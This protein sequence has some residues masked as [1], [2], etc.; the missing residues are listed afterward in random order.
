MKENRPY[1]EVFIRTPLLPVTIVE[2]LFSNFSAEKL[3]QVYNDNQILQEALYVASPSLYY[4]LKEELRIKA[5]CQDKKLIQSL[6][7][8]LIRSSTRCTPFGLFASIHRSEISHESTRILLSEDIKYNLRLDMDCLCRIADEA[9][10]S[11]DVQ[12]SLLYKFNNSAYKVHDKIRY[13]EYFNKYNTRHHFL[14]DINFNKVLSKLMHYQRRQIEYNECIDKIKKMGYEESEAE[15]YM[16]SLIKSQVLISN[17][18]PNVSGQEY[19]FHLFEG[20]KNFKPYE[21]SIRKIINILSKEDIPISNKARE[22]KEEMSNCFSIPIN[23]N[24][25]IQVDSMRKVVSSK[26]NEKVF[27][28]INRAAK[29]LYLLSSERETLLSLEKFKSEFVKKYGLS[30]VPLLLALDKDIGIAYGL[31][32]APSKEGSLGR[33]KNDIEKYKFELYH[34]AVKSDTYQVEIT[35]EDLDKLGNE[36]N[37]ISLNTYS[38]LGRILNSSLKHNIVVHGFHSNIANLIGRFGHLDKEIENACKALAIREEANSPDKIFAEIVHIP[39]GRHGNVI[40]RPHYRKYE[41]PYLAQ[42]KVEEKFQ[43]MPSDLILTV[44]GEKLVLISKQLNC[45]IVPRM[46]NAHNYSYAS[47]PIY[48]FLCDLSTQE[49]RAH[50]SWDWGNFNS[51]IDFSPRVFYKNIILQEAYWVIKSSELLE[52]KGYNG[53]QL[54]QHFSKVRERFG[55]PNRVLLADL[56]NRLALDLGLSICVDIL[57]NHARNAESLFLYEDLCEEAG[58]IV[59]DKNNSIYNS[60]IVLS[61]VNDQI[62]R[63]SGT[64]VTKGREFVKRNFAPYSEWLY[65]KIYC[66]PKI[67]NRIII[68]FHKKIIKPLLKAN[69]IDKWFFIR[70]QDPEQ[71][72]RVRMHFTKKKDL[73]MLFE[74]MQFFF[75]RYVKELIVW[76]IQLD[77]YQRE[78][79]RYGLTTMEFSESVFFYNSRSVANILSYLKTDADY[80]EQLNIA[81][82]GVLKIFEAFEFS[83]QERQ[84]FAKGN[85]KNLYENFN[86]DKNENLRNRIKSEYRHLEQKIAEFL[87]PS[88]SYEKIEIYAKANFWMDK[89]CN[90]IL[91]LRNK[92]R[93]KGIKSE[94][95]H[96]CTSFIHMFL[97][98]F[99]HERQNFQEMFIY[100][101]LDKYY[102]SVV[103]REKY[104]GK[105]SI[106]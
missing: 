54:V 30:E 44:K 91:T 26:V 32:E 5:H 68:E 28:D 14:I 21:V 53:E 16:Q 89:E 4:L 31:N 105:D 48:R 65:F 49:M 66:G 45:E 41:I 20:L 78:I 1:T 19:Q 60:E 35:D 101:I 43:I 104:K 47:L 95:F 79:E 38:F 85:A 73:N 77:T 10:K 99:F 62:N 17:L 2:D 81:I 87:Q 97:N 40:S 94:R 7:K 37:K 70:Y 55:I 13:V 59:S 67:A 15:E 80:N 11:K 9:L 84:K 61:V 102:S 69:F 83:N 100:Q 36:W 42:S 93:M 63:S 106:S 34:R 52:L 86:V 51:F 76:K 96:I 6:F 50:W 71:H 103:A 29:I 12:Q 56:D 74:E 18:T 22:L 8:Y 72:L 58:S 88:L 82:L 57:M 3:F 90:D 75:D 46:S 25:L 98:R 39:Q 92:L 33:R 27:W 23:E 64:R 24:G